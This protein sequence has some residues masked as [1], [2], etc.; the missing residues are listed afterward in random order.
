MFFI[1]SQVADVDVDPGEIEI[2]IKYLPSSVVTSSPRSGKNKAGKQKA[3]GDL[4][5]LVKQACNLSGKKSSK[6][7]DPFCRGLVSSSKVIDS[8]VFLS[9][10]RLPRFW[11]QPSP[12]VEVNL[13]FI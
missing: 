11:F 9:H 5:C 10:F 1:T 13:G 8:L 6:L 4:H 7:P 3:K 12:R 2:E